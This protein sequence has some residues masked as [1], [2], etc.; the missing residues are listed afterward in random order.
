MGK[1]N[2]VQYDL[3]QAALPQTANNNTTKTYKRSIKAFGIWAREQGYKNVQAIRDA[4]SVAVLQQYEQFLELQTS[5]PA[6]IHTR[7]A[8]ICKGLGVSMA[9][10]DKPK[11]GAESLSRSRDRE[12]NKQGKKEAISA[13]YARLVAFQSA[14]GIRRAELA[15]L[16]G[17]DLVTDQEGCLCIRVIRGKGG[18]NQ[19]Q[20]ILPQHQGTVIRIMTAI[21]SDQ[22]VFSAEEMA[23]CIDLHSMRA[24][25]ARDAYVYYANRLQTEPGYRDQ[26]R[27]EL[28]RRWQSCQN[29]RRSGAAWQRFRRELYSQ[30]PYKLRGANR[31]AAANR[32]RPVEYDRLAMMAVSV[33]HLSHWRL[34]V[35]AVNYLA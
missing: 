12:N 28:Q 20:R 15:R 4:G 32:G 26:L 27:G 24:E 22:Q 5:S 2:S 11:R 18:K 9:D 25:L 3:L 6:S 16:K 17:G 7:L 10:I 33:F 29:Q 19:L 35:T 14:V 34:D 31:Q 8:P 1:T 23:N 30:E 21:R 13:K